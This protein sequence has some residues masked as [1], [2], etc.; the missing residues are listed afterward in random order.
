MLSHRPVGAHVVHISYAE[1]RVG[2]GQ[3]RGRGLLAPMRQ[4][5][6]GPP[7]PEGPRAPL[8]ARAMPLGAVTGVGGDVDARSRAGMTTGA[9]SRSTRER[10]AR[11]APSP[12]RSRSTPSAGWALIAAVARPLQSRQYELAASV[13]KRWG[14]R[15]RTRSMFLICGAVRGQGPALDRLSREA[16]GDRSRYSA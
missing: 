15:A 3:R 4:A 14:C 5:R 1:L 10:R 2:R 6:R 13:A 7:V 9:R 16:S 11:R 12:S 8:G